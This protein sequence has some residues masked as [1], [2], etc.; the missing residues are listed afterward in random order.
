MEFEREPAIELRH[1]RCFVRV[2]ELGS[3]ATAA[4]ALGEPVS[5]LKHELAYLEGELGT[6]LLERKLS[7]LVPT[8]AGLAFLLQAQLT[9]RHAAEAVHAAQEPRLT[10]EVSIGM[11]PSIAAVLGLPL[12]QAIRS[13][14]PGVGLHL[15]EALSG[16][17]AAML[18]TRKLDL[19]L[20]YR[21]HASRRWNVNPLLDETL[22]VIGHE[23]LAGMPAGKRASVDAL[24]GVPLVLPSSAHDLRVLVNTLFERANVVPNIVAEIDGLPLLMDA[25]RAGVAATIQP[26]AALARAGAVSLRLVQVADSDAKRQSLL[27][28]LSDDELSP[29]ARGARVVLCDVARQL[30]CSGQWPGASL[31]LP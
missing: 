2:A 1:L 26:G 13:R 19:A 20:V 31:Q 7:G 4:E 22:F 6:P 14:Y 27:A 29:G 11:P 12:L 5:L 25:V 3:V 8:D 24:A 23:E 17:V 28:T 9:L 10:G 18:D 15:V 16:N 30:V 21:S